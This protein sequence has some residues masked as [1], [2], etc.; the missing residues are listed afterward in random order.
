LTPFEDLK[1]LFDSKDCLELLF[2]M[3]SLL[4]TLLLLL[5][6]FSRIW[7]LSI[8]ELLL[9][10]LLKLLIL[11][12]FTLERL[13]TFGEEMEDIEEGREELDIT[14]D[15]IPLLTKKGDKGVGIEKEEIVDS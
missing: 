13:T 1:N 11:I 14:S 7:L 9:I 2:L 12:S 6:L 15:E 8:S 10:L 4:K 5:S 3:L